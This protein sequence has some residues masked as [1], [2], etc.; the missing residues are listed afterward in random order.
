MPRMRRSREKGKA[1]GDE[2]KVPKRQKSEARSNRRKI[3][4]GIYMKH[5]ENVGI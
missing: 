4:S 5:G 3:L 2:R 1:T